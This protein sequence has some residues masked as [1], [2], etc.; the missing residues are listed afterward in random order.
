MHTAG[1]HSRRQA[2]DEVDER[3]FKAVTISEN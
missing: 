1:E 2:A 3:K